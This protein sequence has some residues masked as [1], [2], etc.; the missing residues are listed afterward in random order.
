MYELLRLPMG[1]AMVEFDA[2][3]KK[4]ED[5]YYFTIPDE[6]IQKAGLRENDKAHLSIVKKTKSRKKG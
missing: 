5:S 1:I 2:V 6:I 3:L 4:F